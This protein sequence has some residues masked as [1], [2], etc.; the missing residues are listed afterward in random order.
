MQ[1]APEDGIY[2][3]FRYTET[4][5]VM[6][7][8]NKNISSK[9][10]KLDR[11]REMLGDHMTATDIFSGTLFNLDHTIAVSARSAMIL[12]ID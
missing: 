8:L 11:F 4:D 10:L 3:Y 5:K 6:V 7:I 12:E 9:D 1:F 2:V